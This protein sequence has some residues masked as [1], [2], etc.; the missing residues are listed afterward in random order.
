MNEGKLGHCVAAAAVCACLYAAVTLCSGLVSGCQTEDSPCA[1]GQPGK[2]RVAV[3]VD[4]GSF[5][6]GPYRHLEIASG[7]EDFEAFPV[8]A[9]MIRRGALDGADVLVMPGGQS[10]VELKT[11]G[12]EGGCRIREFV[13]RGGGY[14][15]TC[16]GAYLVEQPTERHPDRLGLIPFHGGAANPDDC[17]LTVEFTE[18]WTNRLGLAKRRWKVDYA[19]GPR[20]RPAA[21]VEG[22]HAE[23]AV[24]YVSEVNATDERERPPFIG[25]GAVVIGT[26][27]KGRIFASAVHP[28]LD[29]ENHEILRAAYRYVTGG[30]G[31]WRVPVR[32]P[33]RLHVGIMS[34][35]SLGVE[36]ARFVLEL[37]RDGEF[38]LTPLNGDEIAFR[39]YRGLDAVIVPSVASNAVQKAGFGR[40]EKRTREFLRRGGRIFAWGASANAYAKLGPGVTC[41]KDGAAAVRGLRELAAEPPPPD[42]PWTSVKKS[43]KP[44][45]VAFFHDNGG[46]SN[47]GIGEAL[48]L[49]SEYDVRFVTGREIADG[50]LANADLVFFPGGGCN[51]QYNALG[52]Q[53]VAAVTNFVRR[54]GLYY[55]ICAG[56]YLASQTTTNTL[57]RTGMIPYRADESPYRGF[58]RV[59]MRFTDEGKRVFGNPATYRSVVYNGGPVMEPG[60]PVPDTDIKVLSE[61]ACRRV[62]VCSPTATLPMAGKAAILGGRVGRGRVFVQGPHPEADACTFDIIPSGFRYLTGRKLTPVRRH[63]VRGAKEVGCVIRDADGANFYIGRLIRQ[64]GINVRKVDPNDSYSQTLGDLEALVIPSPCEK[65]YTVGVKRLVREGRRVIAVARTDEARRLTKDWTGVRVVGS[66]EEALVL[67][68]TMSVPSAFAK[69]DEAVRLLS[70]QTP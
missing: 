13:R 43:A 62:Q 36:T 26:Y 35:T 18:P 34:D 41:V 14:I 9:E 56:A 38:E 65:D 64:G 48:A 50:A 42:G 27:G 67:L 5:A 66:S 1:V 29:V 7:A 2:V 33:G 39:D 49:S 58:A 21:P 40:N 57:P 28:E 32:R 16:A 22:A 4:R 52:E 12:K 69:S 20:F 37:M 61:Y 17:L 44:V 68:A 55:G 8:D 30:R 60:A 25:T 23:I 70:S 47:L 19:G 6:V 24:K 63:H 54:G 15:G 45:R 51:R 11:L 53:G 46:R 3:Y 59:R 10:S 31:A